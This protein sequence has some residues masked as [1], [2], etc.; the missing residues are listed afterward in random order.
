MSAT[1]DLKKYED[2]VNVSLIV[3]LS[4]VNTV[5]GHKTILRRDTIYEIHN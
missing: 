1:V 4:A 5:T 3:T 2:Y